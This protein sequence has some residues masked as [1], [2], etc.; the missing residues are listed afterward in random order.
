M[1]LATRS[2]PK[3]TATPNTVTSPMSNRPSLNVS[4]GAVTGLRL[5]RNW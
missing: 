3:K 4:I 1:T 2:A 5:A